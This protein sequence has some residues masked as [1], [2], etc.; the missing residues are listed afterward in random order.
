MIVNLKAEKGEDLRGALDKISS[1]LK[2][3]TVMLTQK[4]YNDL[5]RDSTKLQ[6]LIAHGVDNWEGYEDAMDDLDEE[7]G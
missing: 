2:Q 5:L 1:A 7:G 3:D 4:E 6:A